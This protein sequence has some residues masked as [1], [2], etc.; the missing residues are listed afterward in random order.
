MYSTVYV[1]FALEE[2]RLVGPHV[3]QHADALHFEVPVLIDV[4]VDA[5][6]LLTLRVRVRVNTE[7]C[8]LHCTLALNY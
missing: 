3:Q 1:E 8:R 6:R 7:T 5:L 4:A 2:D